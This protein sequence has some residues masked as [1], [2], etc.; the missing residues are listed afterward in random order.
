M[1]DGVGAVVGIAGAWHE[2]IKG[3][4]GFCAP[5]SGY[6]AHGPVIAPAREQLVVGVQRIRRME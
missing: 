1:W 6:Q 4:R 2:E 3:E 5:T